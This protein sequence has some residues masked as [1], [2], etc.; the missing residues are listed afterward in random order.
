MSHTITLA[1]LRRV[2][3]LSRQTIWRLLRG[4]GLPFV[5]EFGV[6]HYRVSDVIA[7]LRDRGEAKPD[8]ERAFLEVDKSRR[9][10][11]QTQDKMK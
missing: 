2:T 8:W 7:R 9:S 1:D 5:R 10:R 3:G 11:R 4:Q 6:K